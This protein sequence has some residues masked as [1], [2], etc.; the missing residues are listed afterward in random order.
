M[1]TKRIVIKLFLLNM[2]KCFGVTLDEAK[3]TIIMKLA[4][5]FAFIRIGDGINTVV[6]G[7]KTQNMIIDEGS[8]S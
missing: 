3:R 8:D 7:I 6:D 4:N 2:L 1:A 5:R